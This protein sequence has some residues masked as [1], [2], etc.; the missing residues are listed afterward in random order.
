VKRILLRS[1]KD[2]FE[3]ISPTAT[4]DR[5]VIGDNAGNLVFL[6]A[7]HRILATSGVTVTADRFRVG[8]RSAGMINERFDAYVIPL[9]NAFRIGFE[10]SLIQMTHLIERLTIPVVILGVGAQSN[11]S[12]DLGRLAGIES[13]VRAFVRAVLARGPSI[14]V[15]GELTASYLEFLGFRDVEVI[16]CPSMFLHGD[17]LHIEKRLE[18]LD[19]DARLALTVSPYAGRMGPIVEHHADR[20]PNLTYIAQDAE[21]LERLLWGEAPRTARETSQIP[22]HTSHRLYR[23]NRVRLYCDPWPW[24]DDLRDYDFAFGTRIHGTIAALLA[25]TPAMVLA[26]DSRTLELARYF[27]IP[28]R[29]LSTVGQDVDAADLYAAADFSTLNEDHA[30]RFAAFTDYLG[31][32][33]LEHVF[34]PGEDPTIFERRVAQTRYPPAVDVRATVQRPASLNARLHRGW[35]ALRRQVRS[36]SARR[37]RAAVLRRLGR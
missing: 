26:H 21:T 18:R 1:P 30:T 22:I 11:L 17:R 34:Q 3:V 15:R 25:G 31:R 5:N 9:A 29:T 24:I 37:A 6:E 20:Y 36:S 10:A 7:S 19:R 12:Y 14:G 33:D 35:Y 2:P 8:P 27:G 32:H 16:G 23:E 13:S 28:Y 4:L